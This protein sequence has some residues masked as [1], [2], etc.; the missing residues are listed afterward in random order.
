MCPVSVIYELYIIWNKYEFVRSNLSDCHPPRY[1]H[2]CSQ[3]RQ[4]YVTHCN[5]LI[6]GIQIRQDF[7]VGKTVDKCNICCYFNISNCC[8][9]ALLYLHYFSRYVSCKHC[10]QKFS[11]HV[12]ISWKNSIWKIHVPIFSEIEIQD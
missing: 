9:F 6:S 12:L 11:S 10:M 7:R 5:K 3:P 8:F 1:S 2:I 4:F